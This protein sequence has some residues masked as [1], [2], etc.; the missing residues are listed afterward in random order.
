MLH[1]VS[2]GGLTLGGSTTTTLA[3]GRMYDL[4]DK[5]VDTYDH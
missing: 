5:A 3:S 1:D 4:G 2:A